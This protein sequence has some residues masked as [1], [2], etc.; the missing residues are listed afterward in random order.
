MWRTLQLVFI[1]TLSII[2]PDTERLLWMCSDKT[3]SVRTAVKSTK[4]GAALLAWTG[5][6]AIP[7]AC[8]G[9][10]FQYRKLEHRGSAEQHTNTASRE[11]PWDL[12]E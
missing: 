12:R 8:I 7:D 6:G 5:V 4:R 3:G 1:S 9:V 11:D 2:K 10:S